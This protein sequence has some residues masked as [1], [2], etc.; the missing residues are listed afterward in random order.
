METKKK[1]TEKEQ[2]K[3]INEDASLQFFTNQPKEIKVNK[4]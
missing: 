1:K 3:I 2:I 4:K